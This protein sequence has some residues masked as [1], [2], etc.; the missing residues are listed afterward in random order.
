MCTPKLTLPLS[1]REIQAQEGLNPQMWGGPPTSGNSTPLR[2]TIPESPSA[3]SFPD[4]NQAMPDTT[5]AA[6][7]STRRARAGTLPSRFS[8]SAA[9][10]G[11]MNMSPSPSS[12]SLL[13]KT[14]RPTPST[15]PFKPA[16]ANP[17]DAGAFAAPGSTNA[18]AKSVLLSR[19]RAGS[20]PQR[21]G[22]VP[23]AA[24]PFG[25]SIF[26]SGWSSNRERSSTLH[27]IASQPSNGPGSPMSSF[28]RDSLADT[29]VKT[30]DYLGL[31]DTHRSLSVPSS[32]PRTSSCC[33]RV[34]EMPTPRT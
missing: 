18:A 31:V 1:A 25:N 30:L 20:M 10:G 34:R 7:T 32:L 8:P 28:S 29:D 17:T 6:Q 5:A 21:P 11:F 27:S 26:A 12:A 15:S 23:P 24:S 14:S 2:E 3:D 19:L 13:P 33:S 22:Y 16:T 4:F 9:P